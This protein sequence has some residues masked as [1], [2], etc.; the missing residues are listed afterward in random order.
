[1]SERVVVLTG[2]GISADSGLATFRDA[3]GLWE[4]HRPEEVATPEAFAADPEMV[5]RFYNARR[6]QLQ[7]AEPNDAHRALV[8]FEKAVPEFLLVTQNVDDLHER[9]GSRKLLH[10]HGELKRI[11]CSFC[12]NQ[13]WEEREI[14]METV[15][16]KCGQ[17]GGMRPA[18]VWFGEMPLHMDEIFRALDSCTLFVSIGTSGNV[19][20]AAGFVDAAN[21]AGART[22][23]LNLEPSTTA[24]A[25]RECIH[26]RAVE[27][28]PEFVKSFL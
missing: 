22:V 4:G 12:D 28:V 20:P 3:G 1:M 16:E 24:S 6:L 21:L 18:V 19:Y 14:S 15:C 25:F 17:S 27:I 11:K 2:A 10:M 23:E 26:G 8:D 7:E 5:H 13:R 9:A